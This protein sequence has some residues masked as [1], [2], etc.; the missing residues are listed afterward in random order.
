MTTI[1]C[2]VINPAVTFRSITAFLYL[3]MSPRI[4]IDETESG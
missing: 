4:C 2:L 3:I 1:K